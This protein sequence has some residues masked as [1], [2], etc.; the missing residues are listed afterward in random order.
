MAGVWAFKIGT[1]A[2]FLGLAFFDLCREGRKDF[3]EP[4]VAAM[5]T[6]AGS[7]FGRTLEEFAYLAAFNTF[8]F[9]NRHSKI[10]F[11]AVKT[12]K[13]WLR[14]CVGLSFYSS[15]RLNTLSFAPRCGAKGIGVKGF[16]P[17]TSWSRTKRSNPS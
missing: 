2:A 10:L 16:E 6:F 15:E 5:G 3:F 9:K 8:I 4:F 13:S 1:A 14:L 17:S 12:P 7:F 11:L